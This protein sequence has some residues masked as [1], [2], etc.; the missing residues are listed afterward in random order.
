MIIIKLKISSIIF[1]KNGE[2]DNVN[3]NI[4]EDVPEIEKIRIFLVYVEV[5]EYGDQFLIFWIKKYPNQIFGNILDLFYL[6]MMC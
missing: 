6:Y 5:S 4:A 3:S 1:F 2:D